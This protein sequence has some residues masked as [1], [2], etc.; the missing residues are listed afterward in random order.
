MPA[1]RIFFSPGGMVEDHGRASAG[2]IS[3]P[4][5]QVG[6]IWVTVTGERNQGLSHL[7]FKLATRRVASGH[8]NVGRFTEPER[9]VHRMS[10][11]SLGHDGAVPAEQVEVDVL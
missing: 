6:V 8:R 5:R 11:P 1:V 7:Q 4:F 3:C 9:D 10:G 2:L